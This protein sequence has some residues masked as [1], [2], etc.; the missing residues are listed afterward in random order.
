MAQ[1]AIRAGHPVV[2]VRGA[3]PSRRARAPAVTP[4]GRVRPQ[5]PPNPHHCPLWTRPPPPRRPPRRRPLPHALARCIGD[6]KEPGSG[7]WGERRRSPA[8]GESRRRGDVRR[9]LAHGTSLMGSAREARLMQ[10]GD[11]GLGCRVRPIRT[12]VPKSLFPAL[13]R[14]KRRSHAMFARFLKPAHAGGKPAPR[15]APGPPAPREAAQDGAA[16]G[17]RRAPSPPAE[18][19]LPSRLAGVSPYTHGRGLAPHARP[20]RS[21]PRTTLPHGVAPRV[22]SA[23]R[24]PPG[25]RSAIGYA[26]ASKPVSRASFFSSSRACFSI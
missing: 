21:R 24:H 8:L 11:L 18:Q 12:P 22:R 9:D 5:L 25:S 17:P 23:G 26:A 20:R 19:H 2:Q 4:D 3:P 13:H 10:G 14:L 7:A 15:N 6:E 1:S 16:E